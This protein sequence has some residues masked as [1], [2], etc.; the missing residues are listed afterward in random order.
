[1]AVTPGSAYLNWSGLSDGVDVSVVAGGVLHSAAV[2]ND[3]SVWTWGYNG[4]GELGDGTTT[5]ETS[6][7]R[8]GRSTCTIWRRAVSSRKPVSM[9]ARRRHRSMAR[10]DTAQRG[11]CGPGGALDEPS[12]I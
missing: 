4:D 3:G 10:A 5:N 7:E 12:R 2:T 8:A 6:P 11:R 9:T 1:M